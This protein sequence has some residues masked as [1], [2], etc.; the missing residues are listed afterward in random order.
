MY[1]SH[2]S[3]VG[4]AP[5]P[6]HA[7]AQPTNPRPRRRL[8]SGP[9]IAIRNSA[10]AEGNSP[11]NLATPPKSHRVIPSICMPSRRACIACPSSC[12]TSEVKNTAVAVTP[13]TA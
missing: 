6:G 12:R 10:P 3:S 9:A 1:P 4:T 13:M 11:A 5:E 8:T 2:S 7:T